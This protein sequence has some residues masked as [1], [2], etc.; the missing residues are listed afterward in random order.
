MCDA[1]FPIDLPGG[2]DTLIH[3]YSI[4]DTAGRNANSS[5]QLDIQSTSITPLLPVTLS[6]S[7]IYP[8]KYPLHFGAIGSS[9]TSGDTVGI[10]IIA[11]SLPQSL[12]TIEAVLDI[13]DTDMLTYISQS[14]TNTISL[15]GNKLVLKGNPI[16]APSGILAEF[17]FKI[18]LTKDSTASVS[19]SNVR[20]NSADSD[21]ERCTA[22][23]ASRVE[24]S[25]AYQFACGDHVIRHALS[26]DSNLY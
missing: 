23:S 3:I 8:K 10:R 17:S 21:Y 18:Y 26:N 13:Q 4:L 6:R 11:D 25:V 5:A 19:L 9:Y 24:A 16:V 14:S 22:F 7:Y 12:T 20:F 1:V 15:I 2:H